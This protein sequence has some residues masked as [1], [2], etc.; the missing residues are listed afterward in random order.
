MLE[1]I[2]ELIFRKKKQPDLDQEHVW[3]ILTPIWVHLAFKRLAAELQ[4]PLGFLMTGIFKDWLRENFE[5]LTS[6]AEG[7]ARYRQYLL[8]QNPEEPEK[9]TR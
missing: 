1:N 8:R 6:D 4:L 2:F 5:L 7:K 3:G 9:Y